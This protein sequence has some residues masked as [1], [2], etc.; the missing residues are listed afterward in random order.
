MFY[1]DNAA[2]TKMHPQVLNEMLPYLKDEYGNPD[3]LY[4]KQAEVAKDAVESAREI[5][6]DFF[7]I[8]KNNFIFTSGAT[9]SN[10]FILKGLFF[11]SIKKKKIITTK[12][13]HSSIKETLS[14]LETLGAEV[15]YTP[16]C[17][18]GE[19]DYEFLNKKIDDKTLLV[20]IMYVNNE[21]GNFQNI[22]K[23]AKI[24]KEKN[25]FFHSDFT[26]AVGKISTNIERIEG[27]S[28][29]SVSAHKFYGP[30]G[31]GGIYLNDDLKK[32]IVPLIHGGEQEY[33][34]R[35]GTLPVHQIVG[36]GEAINICKKDYKKNLI[37]LN[38]LEKKLIIKLNEIFGN[39]IIFNNL[40]MNKVPGIVNF[41]IKGMN[42]QILLKQISNF[43]SASS[44]SACSNTKPSFVLEEMGLSKEEINSSI[45]F[46]ISAY[47][48]YDFNELE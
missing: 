39:K 16:I 5:I 27:L 48:D 43:I 7:G 6:A 17:E 42:N 35:A 40:N 29:F 23:I 28:S 24:C 2:T 33:T 10:N 36:M 34:L 4:Y 9:E 30:K 25:V 8:N 19:I 41:Q 45:R 26:Q 11:S 1:F 20:T 38:E 47:D 18:N 31:I 14:Y 21:L 44:G 32:Y 13:E 15:V 12:I 3:S 37:A 22:K 46:S